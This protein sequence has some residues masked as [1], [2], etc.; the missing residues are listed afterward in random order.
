MASRNTQMTVLIP[1]LYVAQ[2]VASVAPPIVGLPA[3]DSLS[4]TCDHRQPG[5]IVQDFV[6]P[7]EWTDAGTST[8]SSGLNST[9]FDGLPTDVGWN[10]Y[11]ALPPN[12]LAIELMRRILTCFQAIS[13]YGLDLG[14]TAAG[15]VG[16]FIEN[17]AREVYVECLNSGVTLVSYREDDGDSDIE[18]YGIFSE[19]DL[20][21]L[22]L[23]ID[24]Y[25]SA[26]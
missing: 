12:D 17:A 16:V 9:G 2:S 20:I 3:I 4:N 19:R 23:K 1:T 6:L 7:I 11:T 26:K 21:E 10:G 25:L 13:V 8:I 22:A 15:G 24:A 5:Q 14:P 18:T